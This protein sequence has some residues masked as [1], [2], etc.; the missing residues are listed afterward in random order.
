M[1]LRIILMGIGLVVSA[2]MAPA[3]E[4]AFPLVTQ[5]GRWSCR[6][7]I[8]SNRNYTSPN[9]SDCFSGFTK[10]FADVPHL[11][12]FEDT[13][14]LFPSHDTPFP[15][16]NAPMTILTPKTITNDG[17]IYPKPIN[18]TVRNGFVFDVTYTGSWIAVGHGPLKGRITPK[19][20]ILSVIYAPPGGPKGTN[21]IEYQQSNTSGTQSS[22]TK[23]F[24]QNYSVSWE[25]SGGFL[26]ANAGGSLGFE[27]SHTVTDKDSLSLEISKT[28]SIIARGAEGG[29]GVN[30]DYDEI[31]IEPNPAVD[32]EAGMSSATM[33][34]VDQSP[35]PVRVSVAWLKDPADFQKQ[36]SP[37]KRYLTGYGITE[38]DYSE[39]LQHDPLAT[40]MSIPDPKRYE[41]SIQFMYSPPQPCDKAPITEKVTFTRKAG[42]GH[43]ETM[44]DQ[45][46]VDL[47]HFDRFGD[48]A[49]TAELQ[50]KLTE[51]AKW[52]WTTETPQSTDHTQLESITMSVG[53]PPCGTKTSPLMQAYLDKDYG[54]YAFREVQG[55]VVLQGSLGPTTQ[56]TPSEAVGI[57]VAE[58]RKILVK[59]GT[60]RESE[61]YPNAKGEWA[62]V[63]DLAFPV[64][65]TINGVSKVIRS[66]PAD[67]NVDLAQ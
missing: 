67:K 3:G 6:P 58:P 26:G 61:M 46:S 5:I 53:G 16:N 34:L 62:I 25:G 56:T 12:V 20:L 2:K 60:G 32:I 28:T 52:T 44:A 4:D 51:N 49:A 27:Y 63:G 65:L 48:S 39:I 45:Y 13:G 38:A 17:F 33:S 14:S 36:A 21:T 42:S 15:K 24:K 54:T 35:A 10:S 43:A 37:T 8:I 1:K 31:I 41:P 29:D 30:N 50:S 23:S 64:T 57:T 7:P 11:L 9:T 59:D 40:G 47:S 22:V 18:Y 19:Y 66:A 55:N